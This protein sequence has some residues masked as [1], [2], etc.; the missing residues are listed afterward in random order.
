MKDKR[1]TWLAGAGLALVIL[2]NQAQAQFVPYYGKNKVKYDKHSWQIYRSPHFEVY[3]YPEF[4]PQLGRL[5]SYAESAYE[6]I[7]NDLKHEISFP[8]PLILYKTFSEFAQT[9]LFPGEVPE[10]VLAF[11]EPV[12]DRMVL[13]I[14]LP[15]DKLM[16]TVQHELVHIFEFDIIPRS[17]VR[18][19]VP[20][21]IDEGLSTYLEG[22][23][24]S[25]DLMIARDAAVTDQI[26]TF[27]ELNVGFTRTPYI[28]GRTIF[29][30]MEERFGRESVRQFLFALRRAVVGGVSADVYQQAFRMEPEE[31]YRLYT[32]WMKERFKPFRDKQIPSDYS[33]DL[34]PNPERQGKFIAA[35]S[36]VPS[37]SREL[38]AVLSFNRRDGELDVILLSVK[39]GSV[40]RN[41][42]P[43]HHGEFEY[44]PLGGQ[45]AFLGRALAW[46]PDGDHV[47]FFGRYKKRRALVMVNV[48]TS[49]VD[50]RI[51]ME[52]DQAAFPH[53]GPDGRYLYFTA[54]RDG[55]ADI[56]RIDLETEE[57]TNL[58]NDEFYDKFAVISPDGQWLYYARRISGN[59]KI[60]RFR[61]DNPSEKQQMTF[62]P[63]DDTGP[64]FSADGRLLFYASNEGDD[65]FNIRSLDLETGDILQYTDVLGGNFG[66]A[67]VSDSETG[68]EQ[69]IFTSYYK[70]DYG[71]YK[72]SLDEPIKEIPAEQIAR[73]EGP[74]IDFVP[75]V[76]HQ[77][78]PE[79]KRKK[80]AFEGLYVAGAPPIAVGVT[81]GGDFFGGSGISFTDVLGDQNFTFV[82]L[83]VR[84]FRTF[85][86]S[87]TNLS[88]RLQYSLQGFD[89][90]SFFFAFNP[91]RFTDLLSRRGQLATIRRSGSAFTSIYPFDRFR[92]FEL[93]AGVVRQR[94]RFEDPF[95]DPEINIFGIG[96]PDPDTFN[97]FK[98]FVERRFPSGTYLP[99]GAAFVQ[100]T[101]RF[102]NF[103]PLSGSSVLLG[104]NISPGGPFLSRRTFDVD[105]RKY[106]QLTSASLFALRLRGFHSSGDGPDLFWF[107][108]NGDLRGYPFLSFVGNRAFF[109][110]AEL[111]FPMV[112]ALLIPGG[113]LFGPIRGAF[114]VNV[115][116]ARFNDEPFQIFAS[117]RRISS[118]AP[119]VLCGPNE[120]EICT[121]DG[122]GLKD[123]VASY[124]FGFTL[125]LFGL[126]LHFDWVKL[127]DFAVTAPGTE[128]DVWVGFDF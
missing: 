11:A 9:N 59:D 111:R 115:G 105:L 98:E 34:S 102:R 63:F 104:A 15:P 81:S 68:Q 60:Y 101:T 121:A 85:Q 50:R 5:V 96:F 84:E 22:P 87:Y 10:G 92:R 109:A 53:F 119:F 28:F 21:W 62:G 37:S 27:R 4:E 3:Y 7:S 118:I 117:D 43:G 110:N 41:L 71:L 57:L 116:G 46:T 18:R 25:M 61:L 72:L 13:P 29:E 122:F 16:E 54:L 2:G 52:L 47:G 31:F 24:D 91:F 93:S 100:E 83:S 51:N 19:S 8:I 1:V 67:L 42:T 120:N 66:P 70:G 74:V 64:T 48:L 76:I 88:G 36:V 106:F 6:K 23:W 79:N 126:P 82:A 112:D 94:T 20:R 95:F 86:G 125:N 69:L 77:V 97:R 99:L 49:K 55:V 39:D 80:G 56:Y 128:F 44:I 65:V 26:P 108:G 58:T 40:L 14:D 75:A 124:G 38:V 103:G 30:F 78:I 114:F 113:L 17:L 35:L 90:T 73:T 107:G 32:K 12:R 127:T 89:Q 123:A 33:L 45:D